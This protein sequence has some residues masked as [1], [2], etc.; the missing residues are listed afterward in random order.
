MLFDI[1]QPKEEMT[2]WGRPCFMAWTT[3]PWTLPSNT[4]LCVGPKFDYVAVRTYNPYTGEKL[5]VVMAEVLVETYFK[6][7]GK[8]IALEDYKP[9]ARTCP[10]RSSASGRV[11]TSWGCAMRSSCLG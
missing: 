4:A 10:G 11:P 6:K 2:G 1:K 3:T 5:T 7:E 8:K 9:G